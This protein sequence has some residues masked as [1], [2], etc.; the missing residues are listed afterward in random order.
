[1]STIRILAVLLV[2]SVAVFSASGQTAK[3]TRVYVS[4]MPTG[5]QWTELQQHAYTAV[6][7]H[8]DSLGVVTTSKQE[9]YVLFVD[10]SE[11]RDQVAVSLLFGHAL[12]DEVVELS[13]KAEVMYSG[14][15]AD[16][17]ATLSKD[18]KWVREQVTEDFVRQFM[19]PMESRIFL[20]HKKD[21]QARLLQGVDVLYEKYLKLRT[22]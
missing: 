17:Q 18:G 5:T 3:P 22:P 21:L 7:T 11:E 6:K 2:L 16:K 9:E 15:P 14:L 20:A 12:P 4:S 1:M 10:A 19:M 8:L 13:K